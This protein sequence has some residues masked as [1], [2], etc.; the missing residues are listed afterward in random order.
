LSETVLFVVAEIGAARFLLPLWRRWL[1]TGRGNWRVVLSTVA[2]RYLESQGLGAGLPV[3]ATLD[4]GASTLGD[5]VAG[6]EPHRML[7]SAGFNHALET[8]AV[9]WARDRNLPVG[10]FIDSWMNYALRFTREGRLC[11]PDRIA[12]IDEMAAN[13]AVEEGLPRGRLAL[14]GQPAWEAARPLPPSPVG[15][16]LFLSGPVRA[17]YDDRLGYD[18][19]SCWDLVLKARQLAPDLLPELWFGRH[20]V[21]TEITEAKV[22]PARLIAESTTALAE[23]GVVLGVFSSPM[24]D[25]LIGGRR[26]ISV[27]PGAIGRDMCPLSRHGRIRRVET[28]EELIAALREPVRGSAELG[29]ALAGSLDRLERFM[30]SDWS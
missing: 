22:A 28:A 17:Q 9:D 7:V 29:A 18:E 5:A 8:A 13:E 25:A 23:V 6:H 10:Q 2:A 14:V 11:L 27:Q 19:W 1:A 15:R 3:A 21:Q 12:V 20:P 30:R 16:A 26:V 4:Q 24:I